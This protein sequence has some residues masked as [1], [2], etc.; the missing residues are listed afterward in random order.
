MAEAAENSGT[1]GTGVR[2]VIGIGEGEGDEVTVYRCWSLSW[3][4]KEVSFPMSWLI[5]QGVIS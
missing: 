1:E 3:R 5:I 4:D 2:V